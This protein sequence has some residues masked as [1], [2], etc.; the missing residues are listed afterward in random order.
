MFRLLC[1]SRLLL[2]FRLRTQLRAEPPPMGAAMTAPPSPQ[3][4]TARAAPT[5]PTT[6]RPLPKAQNVESTKLMNRCFLATVERSICSLP[7]AAGSCSTWVSRYHYDV[8]ASKCVHFWFGSCHGNSNNFVS[9]DECRRACRAPAPSQPHHSSADP[10]KEAQGP[11]RTASP[12]A[13]SAGGGSR[14]MGRIFT[15]H[16]SPSGG[17]GGGRQATSAATQAHRGRLHLRQRRPFPATAAQ[18]S[19][20]AAR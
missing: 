1:L 8:I 5:H 18:H 13:G 9:L 3:D 6:V 7:R 2:P 20:P 11:D 14:N 10:A 16:R 4:P 15:V 12:A 17:G 19:G